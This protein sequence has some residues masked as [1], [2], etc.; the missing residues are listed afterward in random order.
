MTSQMLLFLGRLGERKGVPE[1]LD[2]LANPAVAAQP[3]RAVLAGDGPVDFYRSQ[4]D[5][6][7]LSDRV[8][9]PGWVGEPE[10][11]A[12]CARADFLLLPSRSE[13]MAMAVIEGLASALLVVT[14]RV[15]AHGEAIDEGVDGIFVPVGDPSTLAETLA[16][17][18]RDPAER[19]RLSAG[20][21]AKYLTRFT[22]ARYVERLASFY[23]ATKDAGAP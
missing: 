19:A 3:W 10:V 2:A 21:R 15:G 6:R 17:L 23:R 22:I 1:L 8:T 14:T 9:L 7:G 4:V 12:L 16:R 20:A 11:R 18:L 5:A 13:G